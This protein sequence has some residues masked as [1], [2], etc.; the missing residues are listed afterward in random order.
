MNLRIL[1][2]DD[3]IDLCDLLIEY[4]ATEDFQ[5]TAVHDGPT[6]LERV[7]EGEWD[8]VVLD[9][10]LPGMSGFDVLKRIRALLPVPVLMPPA[11]TINKL[12]PTIT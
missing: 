4:L 8:A 11:L 1:L 7:V 12:P 10:M 5:V 2:I 9:V 6:A 3:D